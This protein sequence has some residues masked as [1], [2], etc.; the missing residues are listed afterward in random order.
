MYPNSFEA[1]AWNNGG[2]HDTGAGYGLKISAADRD[3]HFGR[4]WETVTLRLVGERTS[5]VAEANVAKKTFWNA[6]CREL[7]KL[8]IG[9]WFIENGFHRWS[10]DAPPRF[11]M[12]PVAVREFEVWP[13]GA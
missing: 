12:I 5:R 3:R 6:Q 11:R 1:T 9:Q 2:W 7:I 8:E 4:D 10:R 13:C